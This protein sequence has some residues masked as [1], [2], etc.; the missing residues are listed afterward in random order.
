[1][2]L[3]RLHDLFHFIFKF[4]DFLFFQLK[5]L[6]NPFRDIFILVIFSNLEFPFGSLFL[7]NLSVLIVIFYLMRH[8]YYNFL[9][10]FGCVKLLPLC[11][12]FCNP[13]DC[14]P[15]A[16]SVHGFSRQGYWR[17]LPCPPPGDL[18][19]LESEP[20]FISL[21]IVYILVLWSLHCFFETFVS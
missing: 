7:N 19:D 10:F 4:C 15:P 3:F 2:L 13:V 8:C 20:A 11:S 17:R 21:S 5:L 9:Y 18:P 12:T 16:S 14:S 1:M 6:L